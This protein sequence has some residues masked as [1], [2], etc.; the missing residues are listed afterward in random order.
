MHS[1]QK[2][3]NKFSAMII[4]GKLDNW[5]TKWDMIRKGN[6]WTPQICC[7]N[8]SISLV[9]VLSCQS[10]RWYPSKSKWTNSIFTIKVTCYTNI[11]TFS[12]GN[13]S[14]LLWCNMLNSMQL[15]DN[16]WKFETK[17]Y[18]KLWHWLSKLVHI[19][20]RNN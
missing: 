6:I 14:N 11:K 3:R 4:F 17:K 16:T 13:L 1:E 10:S 19:K 12:F 5:N 15:D 9:W 8:L 7:R 18:L 20:L 2:I